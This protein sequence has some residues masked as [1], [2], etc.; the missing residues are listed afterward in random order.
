MHAGAGG[1]AWGRVLELGRW[2]LWLFHGEADRCWV[3]DPSRHGV[4]TPTLPASAGVR[5]CRC[6]L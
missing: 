4:A 5:V 1:D 2:S 3:E 6:K